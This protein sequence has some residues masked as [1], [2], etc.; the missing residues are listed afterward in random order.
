[1]APSSLHPWAHQL[2]LVPIPPTWPLSR[3]S[4]S[5]L[6]SDSKYRPSLRSVLDTPNRALRR[7]ERAAAK[8]WLVSAAL[9]SPAAESSPAGSLRQPAEHANRMLWAHHSPYKCDKRSKCSRCSRCRQRCSAHR[10]Y[11]RSTARSQHSSLASSCCR[12]SGGTTCIGQWLLNQHC[13]CGRRKPAGAEPEAQDAIGHR[14]TIPVC[15]G[16]EHGTLH[17]QQAWQ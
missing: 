10:R 15:T 9:L 12:C 6:G 7:R 2:G 8:V 16:Q 13:A 17:Q 14:S 11:G 5:Y 3:H 4:C 1:M